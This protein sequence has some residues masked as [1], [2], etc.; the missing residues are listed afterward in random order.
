MSMR[1][2]IIDDEQAT[3]VNVKTMIYIP[4]FH[5]LLIMRYTLV[6]VLL[7]FFS[8]LHEQRLCE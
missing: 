7:C 1:T 3:H 6:I 2:R 8:K 4:F 5:F